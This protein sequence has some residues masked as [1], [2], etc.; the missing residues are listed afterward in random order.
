MKYFIVVILLLLGSYGW[1]QSLKFAFNGRV[2]NLDLGKN[3]GGVT[4]SIVQNGST[5][6]SS[7]S[8]SNGKYSLKA[9]VNYTQ[10]FDV[11]FSKPG[12]VA[13]KV[14]FDFSGLNEEDTPASAEYAP[15]DDLSMSI[16][17]ERETTDFSFLNTEPVA[18]F[19]WDNRKLAAN[20][21]NAQASRMRSK[22]DALLKEA[23]NAAAKL[24]ADYQAAI[25]AG[26]NAFAAQKYEEALARFEE[27]VTYKPN[28]KYPNDKIIELDALI[29]AKKDQEL[30]EKQANQEYFNL[31]DAGDNLRDA[32]ELEKAIAKYKEASGMRPEE[33]YPKDQIAAIQAQ[34][35]KAEEAKANEEAYQAAIKAG[36][37]FM[38]QNSLRPARDK[39]EAASKLK[40]EEAYP[41]QK[42][43]EIEEKMAA[44]EEL[45]AKKKKYDDAIAAGDKAYSE[46]NY[47]AAK[48]KYEEA[49]TYESGSTY[50]KGRIDMCNTEL[51]KSQAEA[52]RLAKIQELL[53]KGNTDLKASKYEDAVAAF[54]EVLTLDAE[55]AEAKTKLAEAQK[56]I[57]ELANEAEREKQY[58]ALIQEGDQAN[59][60]KKL[61]DALAKYQS[62]KTLKDTPEV[63]EKIKAVQEAINVAKSEADKEAK[64]NALIADAQAKFGAD[65]LQGA[66]DKYKEAGAV[67]PTQTEPAKKITEIQA[68]LD[69][70]AEAS[71]KEEQFNAL[72]KAGNDLLAANDLQNAKAKFQEAQK[73]DKSST[74]PQAKINEIDALIA[75]NAEEQAK[76]EKFAALMK[77][78]NDLMAANKLD[79]AKS[80]FQEAQKVDPASADPQKKIEEIEALIAENAANA[81][82]QEMQAQLTAA[83][84]A[85]DKLFNE[86]KWDDS[87]NKYREALTIDPNN[88]YAKDRISTIDLKVEEEKTRKQVEVLLADAKSLRDK[89]KLEDARSKYQEVLTLDPANSIAKAQIDEINGEIAAAQ[90][91]EQKEQAFANL[92]T[93]GMQL[94]QAKKLQEAKQK[95]NEALSYKDDAEVKKTIEEID[96]LIAKNAEEEA[97]AKQQA[98]LD[99]QYDGFI[100]EAQAKEGDKNYSAAI[101]AY[102]KA[103]K[104]KPSETLPKQKVKE[105]NDLLAEQQANSSLNEQY[106]NAIAEAQSHEGSGDLALAITSYE[107][108]KNLKPEEALPKTKIAELKGK[109]EENAAQQAK[110]EKDYKEAMARGE[111]FMA[112]EN[113]L[114]AI[115]AFNEALALKPMESEPKERAAAAEEAERRKGD[116]DA[117]YEKILAAAEGKLGSGDYDKAEELAGRAKQLK[118]EDQ[119]PDDL[120][121][122]LKDLRAKDA[123]YDE[124]MAAGNAQAGSKNYKEAIAQYEKA[125]S[126]KPSEPLPGEKIEEMNR[127]LK[128]ASSTSQ[129]EELYASNMQKGQAAT[130]GKKFEEALNYYQNALSIKPGDQEAQ[131]KV[132]EI[133]QILDDIA[134]ANKEKVE[135]KEKFD[136][137]IK[138]GEKLFAE[139]KYL[140]ARDKFDAAQVIDPTSSYAKEKSVE[141]SELAEAAGRDEAEEQYQKLLKV[142]D[143]S[144]DEENWDKAKDYYNRAI[145]IRK[146]DPYPKKKLE[147]IAL[148]LNPP[149][150]ESTNLE[151]LGEAYNGSI[152]DGGFI[153]IQA[154]ETRKRSKGQKIK[155]ELDK[156]NASQS[157]ISSAN[158]D[159]RLD[160][161]N[162]IYAIWE[163]V[164]VSIDGSDDSREETIKKLRDAEKNREDASAQEAVYEKGDNLSAQEKMNLAKGET[165][166]SYMEGEDRRKASVEKVKGVQLAHQEGLTRQGEQYTQRKYDNDLAMDQI[167]I[168]VEA[169]HKNDYEERLEIE[170]KVDAASDQTSGIYQT[171]SDDTYNKTQK[172]KAKIVQ[173]QSQLSSK[174]TED[175]EVAKENNE[176]VKDVNRDV[177][178]VALAYLQQN[179]EQ[180]KEVDAQIAEVRR[181]VIS[182]NDGF[183]KVREEANDRLKGIQSDKAAS[184][185]AASEGQT[186]KYRANKE[187]LTEEERK[188]KEIGDKAD[189]AMSEKIA[190]VNEMDEQ[191]RSKSS[192]GQLSDDAERLNARQQIVNQEIAQSDK[193]TEFAE[194]NQKNT[195]T[196]K[197]VQKANNSKSTVES[198]AQRDKNLQAQQ[199]LNEV[200]QGQPK[201]VKIANEL[202]QEYPEG[203]SQE[204]FTRKDEAGLVTTVITRRIVVIDGHADVYVR[205]ETKNGITYSKNNKPS[206][207]HVWNSETQGPHLERHY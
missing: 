198:Q 16:F 2:E 173:I 59:T 69:A 197:D 107:K 82:A 5:I 123:K 178:T 31:I 95:L 166:L 81:A 23:E 88:Q 83:I 113:Y 100:Q 180:G 153:L 44:Q 101:A 32:K 199:S 54:T 42:L 181:K 139:K 189:V 191:A 110:I 118:P 200:E 63:N 20:L 93:E 170:R 184:D 56:K 13:K 76:N 30:A 133:Q 21:D 132:N 51:A 124:L 48:A 61:E 78:G 122:R 11:V 147:E 26:D 33:Q 159:E 19:A 90:N 195:E 37:V 175:A 172:E 74:E 201:K 14:N 154:E 102:E 40:P 41:K 112:S 18:K 155:A 36:D 50:A 192:Q 108:A 25:K 144:F 92:K 196:I 174:A 128:E 46:E 45:E 106:D 183:E 89:S 114:D 158:Q 169:E 168:D 55:N 116:G 207:S 164:A 142:A 131:D 203:V 27:A 127:L 29:A 165:V 138:E 57:E 35:D 115:A 120:L 97:L 204:M 151:P 24:E 15:V 85:A 9:D 60:A 80:K 49:L 105:L 119:R 109:M 143:K 111:Q 156:A 53:A 10:P 161:Q 137:L 149:I 52:E 134:N 162:E 125:K 150:A 188:R 87:K 160:T 126:L 146:S 68:M 38:K 103:G 3:E 163:K 66:I 34:I 104:V 202:G 98:E 185:I 64:Y 71:A 176:V 205:T 130:T 8:A 141:C 91:E 22:I 39:Y 72:M 136:D 187:L 86:A 84:D 179:D 79:Q 47:Q 157:E 65:D 186:E 17:K 193:A 152:E 190:Y 70:Q 94:F 77:D 145:G 58:A 167:V 43:K 135:N 75:K 182:D 177:N 148:I 129:K 62:A 4:I 140:E 6:A 7:Q 28:E 1:S 121:K 194:A 99:A 171:I 73:V 117:V 67:D 12:F 96:G 206:L